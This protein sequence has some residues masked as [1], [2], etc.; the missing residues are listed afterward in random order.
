MICRNNISKIVFLS[1]SVLLLLAISIQVSSD[2]DKYEYESITQYIEEN[3]NLTVFSRML[4]SGHLDKT[5]DAGR[6]TVFAFTD[7]AYNSIPKSVRDSL[8]DDEFSSWRVRLISNH[9]FE[10]IIE[11]PYSD[12]PIEVTSIT[13]NKLK[14]VRRNDEHLINNAR[15]SSEPLTTANGVI[16][17][18]DAIIIP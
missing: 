6:Y 15:V 2:E 5:L 10:N 7:D 11:L 3:S 12:F 1:L 18:V 17:L 4:K 8:D 16:M 14:L 9:I 13:G